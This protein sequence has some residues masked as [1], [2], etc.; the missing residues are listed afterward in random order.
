M[1]IIYPQ[2]M[3]ER[4]PKPKTE[5]KYSKNTWVMFGGKHCRV[6]AFEMID[7]YPKYQL[8]MPS[9]DG[10]HQILTVHEIEI[11]LPS[12]IDHESDRAAH[13]ERV[14]AQNEKYN[15]L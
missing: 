13:R 12:N 14:E 11:D 10:L 1:P 6:K 8:E 2:Q 5:P 4:N 7:G 15:R 3:Q 9:S